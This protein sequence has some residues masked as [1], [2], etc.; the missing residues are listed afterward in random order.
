MPAQAI[1]IKGR[2]LKPHKTIVSPLLRTRNVLTNNSWTFL[3]LWMLREKK[4]KAF[5]YWD[6]AREFSDAA[7]GL[8]IRSSPVRPSE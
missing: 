5:F 3:S 8:P 1:R 6:E 2:E 4:K 7:S